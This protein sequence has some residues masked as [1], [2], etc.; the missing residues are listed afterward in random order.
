MELN[1][2]GNLGSL[3]FKIVNRILYNPYSE[4]KHEEEF[5]MNKIV[6]FGCLAWITF[7]LVITILAILFCLSMISNVFQ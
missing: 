4:E 7:P 6:K 5:D 3:F 1:R 2:K